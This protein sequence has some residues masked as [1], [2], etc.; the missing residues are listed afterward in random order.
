VADR[1][2]HASLVEGIQASRARHERF[3]HN[4]LRHLELLLDKCGDEE[5]VLLVVDGVY[6]MMGDT[7]DVPGVVRLARAHGARVYIDEAHGLGVLGQHGCGAAEHL[8]CL[9]DVDLVAGG[10]G[11]A[12]A[13][14][15]GFLAGPRPVIDYVKHTSRAFIY[16]TSMT[17]ASVASALAA[18]HI[19]RT[20]PERRSRLLALA[21]RCRQGLRG[22]GLEVGDGISPIIPV[23]IGQDALMCQVFHTLL[24]EGIYVNPV[25]TPAAPR[26]ML[27]ISCAAGHCEADID[28]LLDT[29]GRVR[30]RLG[31][32]A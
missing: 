16:S 4:D 14:G 22:L 19:V 13:C 1:H 20:E 7:A 32:A 21:A 17:P 11:K 6:S 10:L 3:G 31:I 26:A 2:V 25:L 9:D 5:P 27:R 12:L 30:R 28:R 18:L 24:E 23:V 15:G 8:G 29:L